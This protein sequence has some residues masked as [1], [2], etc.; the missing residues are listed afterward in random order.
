MISESQIQAMALSDYEFRICKEHAA[1]ANIRGKSHVDP[2]RTHQL[3]YQL[4]G[5]LCEAAAY[6]WYTGRFD[7]YDQRRLEINKTPFRGDGGV[8][9]V[10]RH[11]RS[12]DTKGSLVRSQRDLL[13][14]NLWVRKAELKADRY[15]LALIRPSDWKLVFLVGWAPS[16]MLRRQGDRYQLDAKLLYPMHLWEL[17]L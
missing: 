4:T 1:K 6:M 2:D 10:D 16:R 11:D 13:A 3:D 15:I 7:I 17:F 14:H 8:D 5:Q 12:V 9:F